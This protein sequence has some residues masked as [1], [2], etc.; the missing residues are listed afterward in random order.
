MD[1]LTIHLLTTQEHTDMKKITGTITLTFDYTE[2]YN[3]AIADGQEIDNIEEW[4]REQCH[5]DVNEG[6]ITDGLETLLRV[7]VEEIDD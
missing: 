6:D 7:K 1:S 2:S 5:D 4:A 3:E